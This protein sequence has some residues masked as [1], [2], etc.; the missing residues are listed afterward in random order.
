MPFGG[1]E[2]FRGDVV[3]ARIPLEGSVSIQSG[4]G[5]SKPIAAVFS[6]GTYTFIQELRIVARLSSEREFLRPATYYDLEMAQDIDIDPVL[7][8]AVVL[9]L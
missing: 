4:E 8:V 1:Y 6:G 5:V 3:V 2:V 9:A 7:I